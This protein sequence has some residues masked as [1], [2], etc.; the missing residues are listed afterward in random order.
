MIHA[1]VHNHVA[2]RLAARRGVLL[3]RLKQAGN[4]DPTV[5]VRRVYDAAV[6]QDSGDSDCLASFE[7]VR[8]RIKRVRAELVPHIPP[9]VDDIDIQ[10][11]WRCT[12]KNR[13]FLSFQDNNWGV[14]VFCTNLMLRVL[15]RCECLYI[16]GT[17]RTAPHPYVQFLTIHG[18]YFGHVI[19]LIFCL[20]TGKTTAQ[21]R[22]IFQHIKIAVRR[23]T[24]HNFNPRR[25]VLDFEH[26]LIL[27]IET[28]LPGCRLL[29]CYF[30]FNQSLWRNLQNKG[31][32]TAYRRDRRLQGAARM[33]MALGFLP[34]L[35][36][37]QNFIQ[38]RNRR[39]TARV[40]RR[41]P[42]FDDWL[43]YVEG[44]YLNN[45][46]PFPPTM[47]NVFGR[48]MDTRTNNHVEGTD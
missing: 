22:Q 31:L 34:L 2:D 21:Y 45:N 39:Q 9:T 18:L 11:N 37:R 35:L 20:V 10:G 47:W 4:A 3:K 29:G 26:G 36:V 30:H 27:A 44:T 43:D 14:A 28:E 15:Q 25:I 13:Q 23:T 12:W 40:I 38:L 7:S 42:A 6:E 32:A 19:P 16:D 5:P 24:H 17:F 33:V 48:N 1:D 41:H 8:T 46:S